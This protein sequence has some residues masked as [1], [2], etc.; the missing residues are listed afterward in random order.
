[1]KTYILNDVE[2]KTLLEMTQN[3]IDRGMIV[4]NYETDKINKIIDDSIS[5]YCEPRDTGIEVEIEVRVKKK[6]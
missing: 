3:C 4:G 1:M 6:G 5:L 2:S